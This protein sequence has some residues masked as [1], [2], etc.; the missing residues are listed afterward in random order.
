MEHHHWGG[1]LVI[2]AIIGIAAYGGVKYAS[3]SPTNLTLEQKINRAQ[4][5]VEDLKIKIQDEENSRNASEYK[6]IVTLKHINKSADPAQEYVTIQVN[7]NTRSGVPITGWTIK[8]LSSGNSYTIPGA[9]G[10]FFTGTINAEDNVVLAPGDTVYVITGKSPIGYGF[11]TNICSGYQEQFQT[12][13]PHIGLACPRPNTENLSS[14][15]KTTINDA[16]FDYIDGLPGCRIQTAD[17]P[18]NLTPECKNFIYDKLNYASC[19]SVHK[20]DA[21][22]YQPEWRIYLKRSQSVWKQSHEHIV[23][24]DANGKI[25]DSLTY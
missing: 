19:V 16:C 21:T 7:Q 8:S 4:N 17:V 3:V 23:L 9:T 15:P 11:R 20:N 18:V 25:V 5:Q 22:F 14:I 1:I 24:Y 13:V 2:L 6:D 12:F 10:L